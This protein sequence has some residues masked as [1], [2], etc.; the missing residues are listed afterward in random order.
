LADRLIDAISLDLD[1]LLSQHPNL[2]PGL[3]VV[4][5]DLVRQWGRNFGETPRE[6]SRLLLLAVADAF[7]VIQNS[8]ATAPDAMQLERQQPPPDVPSC[9]MDHSLKRVSVSE[10]KPYTIGVEDKRPIGF[11]SVLAELLKRASCGALD[12]EIADVSEQPK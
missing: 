6:A 9:K 5:A 10:G 2:T 8:T 1:S 12:T 7:E 11:P 3:A 4:I